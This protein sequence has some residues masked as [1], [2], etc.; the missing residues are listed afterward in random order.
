MWTDQT[1]LFGEDRLSPERYKELRYM[2]LQYKDYQAQVR[3]LYNAALEGFNNFSLTG[4]PP[5]GMPG[6][7]TAMRVLLLDKIRYKN[8]RI[9]AIEQ[10]AQEAGGD[11]APYLLRHVTTRDSYAAIDPPCSERTF[12]RARKRFFWAL[13]EKLT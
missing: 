4:L 3:E 10:S 9:N 11:L 12:R 6:D 2:C 1:A 5:N 8:N 7:S 13:N